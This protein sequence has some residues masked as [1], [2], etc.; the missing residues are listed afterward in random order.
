MESEF[1]FE[2]GEGGIVVGL[3]GDFL[4][5]FLIDDF[6]VFAYDHY[7]TCQKSCQRAVAKLYAELLPEQ[8]GAESG[9]HNDVFNP[10]GGTE[11]FHRKGQVH[12]YAYHGGILYGC[13]FLVEPAHGAGTYFG[14]KAGENV[15]YYALSLEVKTLHAVKVSSCEM[16]A[17]S[18]SAY[19]RNCAICVAGYAFEVNCMHNNKR[20][21]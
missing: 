9:G 20:W 2:D 18:I 3:F 11:T 10:F 7:G 4:Y 5:N 17:W 8:R 1:V 14:V 16:E 21:M 19:L 15:E 13:R 6:A 12:R